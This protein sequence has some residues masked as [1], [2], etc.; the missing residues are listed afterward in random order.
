MVCP[1]NAKEAMEQ[2]L[3]A[4]LMYLILPLWIAAGFADWLCH[5]RTN[6]AETAGTKESVIHIFMFSQ[7]GIA[8]CSAVFLSVTSLTLCLMAGLLVAHQ[9]TAYWDL[10]YA[11][12]KREITPLEQQIHSL[13]EML[14]F[15]A[16]VLVCI[17][18]WPVFLETVGIGDKEGTWGLDLRT[19]ALPTWYLVTIASAVAL[20]SALPY[21]V[22]LAQCIAAG[23]RRASRSL[24]D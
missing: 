4:V 1:F 7:M 21:W 8:I 10:H 17:A 11:S 6:I 2:A 19:P 14:P 16:L 18:N 23:R 24:P 9:L 22:E 13:L 15:F 12:N 20:F 3:H 5:R